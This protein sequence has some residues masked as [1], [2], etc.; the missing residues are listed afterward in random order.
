MNN[1]FAMV[2]V[3]AI[4]RGYM[5]FFEEAAGKA[6]TLLIWGQDVIALF[7]HLI[8]KDHRAIHPQ[9]A[10][11]CAKALN[12]FREVRVIS[13]QFL[14]CFVSTC[15]PELIILPDEEQCHSPKP[16]EIVDLYNFGGSSQSGSHGF[17]G[18]VSSVINLNVRE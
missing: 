5:N 3:P 15:E 17:F 18:K 16:M 9:T 1:V 13:V 8:R 7:D 11:K 12:I 6:D 4:H 2:Y 14:E 10:R